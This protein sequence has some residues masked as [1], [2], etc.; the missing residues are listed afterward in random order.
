MILRGGAGTKE[1]P[2]NI[3]NAS[4]LAG[5]AVRVNGDPPNFTMKYYKLTNDTFGAYDLSD[6]FWAP[7]ENATG[8]GHSDHMFQGMFDGGNHTIS[9]MN[10]TVSTSGYAGLFGYVK[11]AVI[12]NVG[13]VNANVTAISTGTSDFSS[14]SFSGGLAGV[15]LRHWLQHHELLRNR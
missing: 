9:N 13:V 15:C 10:V 11:N 7:I 8:D 5:V 14:S 3:T 12:Q 1:N 6:H 2:Y 4:Q